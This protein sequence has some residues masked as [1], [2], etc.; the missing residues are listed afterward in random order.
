MFLTGRC[1][2]RVEGRSDDAKGLRY[3]LMVADNKRD[4]DREGT[5]DIVGFAI[6]NR[7]GARIAY[8]TG[9]LKKGDISIAP[10]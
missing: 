5:P 10:K 4:E 3:W 1:T 7:N 9:P 2:A 8:G 6:H